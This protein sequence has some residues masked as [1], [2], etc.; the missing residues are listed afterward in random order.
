MSNQTQTKAQN[1]TQAKPRKEGSGY[2][3]VDKKITCNG[4]KFLNFHRCG[5]RR[6]Q[7]PGQVRPLSSYVNGDNYKA[8]LKPS[9]C[10]YQKD[11]QNKTETKR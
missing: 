9:D 8:F 10:D 5:C 7:A 11:Q 4:C 1:K 6:N 3:W 2:Y